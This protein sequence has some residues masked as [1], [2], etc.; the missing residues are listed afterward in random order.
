MRAFLRSLPR[1]V[2][3]LLGLALFAYP[4][5]QGATV[6]APTLITDWAVRDT[7]RPVP[8]AVIT[9]A[10]CTN[11]DLFLQLCRMTVTVD[12]PA[13]M[14]TRQVG[15]AFVEPHV[16]P[17]SYRV[18]VDPARPYWATTTLG[19][20]TL[21]DRTLCLGVMLLTCLPLAAA[22]MLVTLGLLPSSPVRV[23]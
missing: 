17:W 16:G 21:L 5:W 4:L 9:N 8:N 6:T 11:V 1:P 13:G 15:Y 12:G 14:I 22:A 23:R 19:M 20:D 2:Q 18:L 7:A 10:R 3:G